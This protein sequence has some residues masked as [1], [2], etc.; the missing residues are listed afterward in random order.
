[1]ALTVGTNAYLTVADADAYHGER[2]RPAWAAASLAAREAA[3]VAATDHIDAAY[4]FVGRRAD[5]VQALSW[6]R[7]DAEAVDGRSLDSIPS[8]VV[9]ATAELALIALDGPLV[10]VD[11]T[12]GAVIDQK[13]GSVATRFDPDA[14]PERRFP[15]VERLL[16]PVLAGRRR[17]GLV[18]T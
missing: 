11:E 10:P 1:M 8:P 4:R 7:L 16:Q 2:G 13:L 9:R 17:R 14:S 5:P 15:F 18:R 3:I 12:G 6:P